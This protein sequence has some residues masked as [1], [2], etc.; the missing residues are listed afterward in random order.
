MKNKFIL[1][2]VLIGV[3][4]V[5]LFSIFSS[6][7]ILKEKPIESFNLDV[8][9]SFGD[10]LGFDLNRSALSFGR[11]LPGGTS[12]RSIFVENVYDV[13]FEVKMLISP[14]INPFVQIDDKKII[15]NP[16][17]KKKIPVTVIAPK[18]VSYG[19]YEGSIQ[20]EL[21]SLE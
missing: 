9:F 4:G 12:T 1:L 13:P 2:T 10:S 19:E 16:G 7:N 21:H 11:L 6:L 8:R 15:V 5:S 14:N 3:V 18:N 20:V 17:E